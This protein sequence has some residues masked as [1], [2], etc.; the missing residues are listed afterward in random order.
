MRIDEEEKNMIKLK[1]YEKRL[2]S[3]GVTSSYN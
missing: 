1:E 2:L 3:K